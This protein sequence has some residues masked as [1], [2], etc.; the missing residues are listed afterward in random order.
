M[1]IVRLV[2]QCLIVSIFW[3]T[4]SARVVPTILGDV[5][6]QDPV[7]L[8][9]LDSKAIQR[10]KGIDQS[11]PTPYFKEN[12]P[13]LSRYDHSLGVYA[14]LKHFKVSRSEQI[15]GLM[16]DASHTV[17][18]HLADIIFLHGAERTE[19]YQDKIHD[20]FLQQ[21]GVDKILMQANLKIQDISPKNPKFRALEQDYPDMNADRIE[22][23]LHTGLVFN[24]LN[25][26]DIHA[27][28]KALR[29]DNNKWYFS[30]I[31]HAKQLAKL[32][33]YYTKNLWSSS[34]NT[35]FYTV[36]AAALQYAL[37]HKYITTA[38]LNFG[39]DQEIVDL[40]NTTQ[41]PILQELVAMLKD[42]DKYYTVSNKHDYDLYQP[43][44]M[45]GFDPLVINNGKL[46]RLSTLSVDF[47]NELQ[48]TANYTQVGIYLKFTNIA[49]QQI[50]A[51]L[52][53][54]NI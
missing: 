32:S 3:S 38:N 49:N 34:H 36:G 19:S 50:L 51:L 16:H 54:A 14:L 8:Q 4:A 24:D 29:Y 12:Y 33:T 47:A 13:K 9:L 6:E 11:G 10:L 7:I 23:N 17:F 15:A 18:S 1:K 30:D 39:V 26:D 42:I 52:K 31:K 48:E 41:D 20:W 25:Q 43:V 45:R 44:K 21:M 22:Y 40:L 2:T 37:A 5:N 35:A 53:Q 27:I 28:I 46:A